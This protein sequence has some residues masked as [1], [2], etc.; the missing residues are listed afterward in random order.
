MNTNGFKYIRKKLKKTQKQMAHLLGVSVKA[1]HS[2]EQGWRSIPVHVERQI[3]FLFYLQNEDNN[4]KKSCW[5]L[6]DCP[7]ERMHECPS[8]EFRAGKFCWMINGTHCEGVIQDNWEKKMAM[9]RPCDVF[10][11]L[12]GDSIPDA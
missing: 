2:Y 9:C 4:S 3:L 5:E 12:L 10:S 1:V 6:K 11:I 7:E 8:W